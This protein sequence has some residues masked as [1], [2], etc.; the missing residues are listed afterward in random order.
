MG[1]TKGSKNVNTGDGGGSPSAPPP[2]AQTNTATHEVSK[3]TIRSSSMGFVGKPELSEERAEIY[4]DYEKQA[5][6]VLEKKEEGKTD[7]VPE[8]TAKKEE[9]DTAP[10]EAGKKEEEK[11]VYEPEPKDSDKKEPKE[12]KTVPYDALHAEREKRKLA[13]AKIRELEENLKA[14]E[15]KVAAIPN[16]SQEEESYLT[17][18]ERRIKALEASIE[19][20]KTKEKTREY[21]LRDMQHGEAQRKLETAVADTDKAL[22]AE[23]FPG[24][25]FLSNKIS[26][27]LQKLVKDDPDNIIFDNPEG[28]KKIYKEKVFP[29]VKSVFVKA[30]KEKIMEDKTNAK[31]DA[32]LIG[33]P[34]Q[35]DKTSSP[36]KE[37]DDDS[38]ES[39]LKRRGYSG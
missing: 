17:D 33:S 32:S 19:E 26:E 34:G 24:F 13:Q 11:P 5:E 35:P 2:A 36:K 12:E 25:K 30:E 10:V 9:T 1:R 23:G 38:Y 29:H 27:E 14:L 4:A 37:E 16:K 15:A 21:E 18:E 22:A 6:P 20:I 28:W 7:T 39:Y 31:K 3:D 8:E